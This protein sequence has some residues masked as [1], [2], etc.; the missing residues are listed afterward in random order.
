MLY[1]FYCGGLQT[2]AID[3]TLV[4]EYPDGRPMPCGLSSGRRA[5]VGPD[6]V[7]GDGGIS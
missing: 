3:I 4:R 6:D 2:R 7:G 5:S 1:D